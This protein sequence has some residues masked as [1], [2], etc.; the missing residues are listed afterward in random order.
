MVE[1]ADGVWRLGAL[2]PW[3]INIYLI[4]TPEGDVLIDGGTRWAAGRV[5]RELRGRRLA[6]VALTHVHPAHQGVVAAVCR[7]FGVPL[8]CHEADVDVMEGRSPMHPLNPLTRLFGRLWSGPPWPVSVRWRGGEA[9]GEWRVVHLPGHT[10][11][12]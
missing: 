8:A 12:H 7:R 11:G 10:P 9:L 2:L 1:V 3:V 5:L 4:R 6:M